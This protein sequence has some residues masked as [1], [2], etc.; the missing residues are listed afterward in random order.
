MV[1]WRTGPFFLLFFFFFFHLGWKK[2]TV[3]AGSEETHE[4]WKTLNSRVVEN[5]NFK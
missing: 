4:N 5:Q 1:S 3:G 2:F